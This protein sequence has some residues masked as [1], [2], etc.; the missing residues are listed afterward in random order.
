VSLSSCESEIYATNEG[1]KSALNVR[2][3]LT[4]LKVPEASL[5][6]PLWNDNRGTV[7]WTNGVSVSK[8]LRHIN[9]RELAV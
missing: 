1:T 2:N 6:M 8:K 7:D 3:L 9:M 4:D 5:P